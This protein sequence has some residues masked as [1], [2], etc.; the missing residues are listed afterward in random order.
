MLA[1]DLPVQQLR[2]HVRINLSTSSLSLSLSL[3]LNL[4]LS[5]S[6]SLVHSCSC[7]QK[8]NIQLKNQISNFLQFL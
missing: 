4:S 8:L 7:I 2:H 5:L 1:V 3:S 6:L